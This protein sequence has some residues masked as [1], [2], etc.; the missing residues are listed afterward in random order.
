[1]G[2][3]KNF[4]EYLDTRKNLQEK[5]TVDAVAD[6]GPS[7][8]GKKGE[9]K[10]TTPKKHK[11][12]EEGKADGLVGKPVIDPVADTGPSPKK[13]D[14]KQTTPK[15]HKQVKEGEELAGKPTIELVADY[16]GNASPKPAGQKTVEDGKPDGSKDDELGEKGNKDLIYKPETKSGSVDK[17]E[18][19]PGFDTTTKGAKE[20]QMTKTEAFL[21]KTKDM[22]LKEFTEYMLKECGC[23]MADEA[24]EDELPMVNAYSAGK[25][26]PYPPEAIKYVVVLGNKNERVME[27]L[28]HEM[29]RSG[30]L[31]KLLKAALGHSESF[32]E[33]AG[34]MDHNDD[35]PQHA[36]SLA[37]AMNSGYS[38]FLEEQSGLYESVAPPV[39]FE[40][41]DMGEDG[42]E[43]PSEEQ[44]AEEAPKDNVEEQPQKKL[45]RKFADDHLLGAMAGYSHMREKMKSFI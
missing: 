38:K 40:D 19:I 13:M 10:E 41:D 31:G 45:K 32:D 16:K 11:Q 33:L 4:K 28:V 6:T 22:S 36:R 15:K 8:K 43:Q 20:P 1:M 9:P 3:F 27:N 23:Q 30:A 2:S 14:Q 12:V 42:A 25:F 7:P 17:W 26:H 35:G 29:K 5:P 18:K 39:G 24:G 44:P 21:A 34:L 37:R